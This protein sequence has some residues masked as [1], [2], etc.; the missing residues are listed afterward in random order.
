PGG[1]GQQK[2][3]LTPL[4]QFNSASAMTISNSNLASFSDAAVFVH[5]RNA[6]AIIRDVSGLAGPN[7]TVGP[8]TRDTT[9]LRGQ[10]VDLFMYGN[11]ISNS[12]VGIE[13][14]SD[15]ASPQSTGFNSPEN[16]VLL[17]NTF[18][19][20]ATGLHT[21]GFGPSDMAPNNHVY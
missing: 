16:L 2:L 18:Y 19:N 5:A 17:H 15:A 7:P 11:T 4:T 20:D 8:P 9:G 12:P 10:G 14:H 21:N 1:F 3:G 13:A 6:N